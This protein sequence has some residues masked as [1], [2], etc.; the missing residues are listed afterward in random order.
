MEEVH[1]LEEITYMDV[2][3]ETHGI[4]WSQPGICLPRNDG[5][6]RLVAAPQIHEECRGPPHLA[7]QCASGLAK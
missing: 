2:W 5:P 6:R 4:S 3:T 7:S 1:L